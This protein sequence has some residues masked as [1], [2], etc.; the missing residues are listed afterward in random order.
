V[1]PARNYER[2]MLFFSGV[3]KPGKTNPINENPAMMK[4][5]RV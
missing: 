5:A 4:K 3:S 2:D 1:K